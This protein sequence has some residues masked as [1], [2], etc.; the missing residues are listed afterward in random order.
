MAGVLTEPSQI[1]NL[2]TAGIENLDCSSSTIR[3]PLNLI[4]GIA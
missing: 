4:F 1:D 3:T 2:Y